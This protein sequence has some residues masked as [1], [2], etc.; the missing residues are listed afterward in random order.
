MTK[1]KTTNWGGAQWIGSPEL[2]L[3]ASRRGVFGIEAV[4][5]GS[6][7]IVFGADDPRLSVKRR[8]IQNQ[9]GRSR[10]SY[11]LDLSSLP[12]RLVITRI[13]Y[14]EGDSEDKPLASV[15]IKDINAP[16]TPVLTNENIAS[17]HTL[18]VEVSGNTALTYLDGRLI[19]GQYVTPPFSGA[20]VTLTGRQLNPLGT[21]DIMTFPRLSKVGLLEGGRY[22]TFRIFDLRPPKAELF[23]VENEACLELV[24]KL[25]DPSHGGTTVLRRTLDITKSIK[26][27]N[28]YATARGDYV[29]AVNGRALN[30]DGTDTGPRSKDYFTPGASQFDKHLFYHCYDVA[31]V[32]KQGQN[33]LEFTLGSGWW[34]DAQSFLMKDFNFW[35]NNPALLMKLEIEYTDGTSEQV[36]SDPDCWQVTTQGP[37]RYASH[38]HGETYDARMEDIATGWTAPVVVD[39]VE[40]PATE[41]FFASPAIN[42]TQPELIE[43]IGNPVQEILTQKA[44]S[45]TAIDGVFIYDMGQN[46]AGVPR[47]K[48]KAACGQV[49]TLRFGETLY[50]N[51]PEYGYLQGLLMTENLRDAD[52]TDIYICKGDPDGEVIFPRFTFHGFRYLELSGIDDAP[53]VEDV[54]AVVLSSITELSGSFACSNPMVNK[55]YE[56]ILWS[57]RANF[58]SIPT[59]CPQRN[60]RMGWMGDAQ[61]FASTA[62]YNANVLPL[63]E[64]YLISVRDL[65]R[66]DG[67]FPA[68]APYGGGFGGILWESAGIIIP[69]ELYCQYGERRMLEDNYNA[70]LKYIDYL[71]KNS[72]DNLLN[73]GVGTLGDWLAVDMSTDDNLVWNAMYAYDVRIAADI[74]EILGDKTVSMELNALFCE[75]KAAWNRVFVEPESGKTRSMDGTINDTQCSYA[76]PLYYSVFEDIEKAAGRLNEKTI[77]LDYTLTTGFIGTPCISAALSDNGYI[78]TAYKLLQQTK[79]PSWLYPVTQGATSI[80]ERWNS[81]SHEN[82]FGGNNGMNS[83]NHYS[84]GAVGAWLYSRVLG[85]RPA[86]AGY[87]RIR[88]EP[89]IGSLTWAEGKLKT[90]HGEVAVRWERTDNNKT[91][92]NVTVPSGTTAEVILPDGERHEVGPGV[93]QY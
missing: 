38:F 51:L 61:V 35:G 22:E 17:S 43:H 65:Q 79:Y 3:D 6:G 23:R 48:I 45:V 27:A 93:Y 72:T 87:K 8:N 89:H 1:Y 25:T 75:I 58:L 73:R 10:I 31:D 56:N 53:S 90:P 76:L 28:L 33:A 5:T 57:Q 7:G 86:E 47:I 12:G 88:I 80:W 16:D 92:L 34:S 74:A 46:L 32:L 36:V 78:D 49:I 84:L 39:P 64:R 42:C 82:G 62:A 40:F 20:P 70:I 15:E 71:R 69:W 4:F 52:C 9:E 13:G 11:R 77:E 63:F 50:P 55:L 67:K 26:A 54:E 30:V 68:I 14:A 24:G 37:I 83:F 41:G 21:N 91:T 19:D 29:G 81:L 66:E 60:E 2:S 44:R 59:D 85:I 18:T